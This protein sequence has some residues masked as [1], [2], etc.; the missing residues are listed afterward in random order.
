METPPG[1]GCLP[2]RGPLGLLG[3]G[4]PSSWLSSLL[5]RSSDAAAGGSAVA[6]SSPAGT[7][8]ACGVAWFQSGADFVDCD[9]GR[10]EMGASV[11]VSTGRGFDEGPPA[12][13]QGGRCACCTC[14]SRSS[15]PLDGDLAA[16]AVLVPLRAAVVCLFS[17][18][19]SFRCRLQRSRLTWPF[20][21]GS[22]ALG[23]FSVLC[24]DSFVFR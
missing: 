18:M 17:S 8:T 12:G 14:C 7:A 4:S 22:S 5:S 3:E 11:P 21:W 16:P 6:S 13:P 23:L 15:C 24:V 1:H 19:P 2:D 20:H 10:V 9:G